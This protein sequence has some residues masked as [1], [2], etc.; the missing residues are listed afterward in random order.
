MSFIERSI[1]RIVLGRFGDQTKHRSEIKVLN[2]VG[3]NEVSICSETLARWSIGARPVVAGSTR[4]PQML[5]FSPRFWCE[6]WADRA[7]VYHPREEGRPG[8][9]SSA[10]YADTVELCHEGICTSARGSYT[11][12]AVQWVTSATRQV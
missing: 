9:R 7:A 5:R 1:Q 12:S 2:V 4:E 8:G 10:G 6:L 3:V 11:G